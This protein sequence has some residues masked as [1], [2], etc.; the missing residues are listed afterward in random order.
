MS[1]ATFNHVAGNASLE[2]LNAQERAWLAKASR[3]DVNGWVHLKTRGAPF[4]RGFQHGFLVAREY[5]EALRVYEAMT[6]QTIG[7]EY[8][9]FVDACR[10]HRLER[11]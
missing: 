10:R 2:N 3:T 6:L 4:E 7:R 9:F 1:N 11:L 8:A 5:A